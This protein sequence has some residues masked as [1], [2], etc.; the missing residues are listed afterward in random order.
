MKLAVKRTWRYRIVD[1]HFI[2]CVQLG[3]VEPEFQEA[4]DARNARTRVVAHCI[5]SIL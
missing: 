3:D 1:P 4:F 5:V 2:F